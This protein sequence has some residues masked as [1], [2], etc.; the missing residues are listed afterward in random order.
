MQ[1][2]H[3]D[4]LE[5]LFYL[6]IYIPFYLPSGHSIWSKVYL[7]LSLTLTNWLI[8]RACNLSIGKLGILGAL[9]VCAPCNGFT[10]AGEMVGGGS[11]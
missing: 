10:L 7:P 1:E 4:P 6:L 5:I 8:V 2:S 9:L 3:H 11:K